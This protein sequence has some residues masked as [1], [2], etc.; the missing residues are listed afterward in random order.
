MINESIIASGQGF[1]THLPKN[2]GIL[3]HV[4]SSAVAHRDSMGNQA[5][6]HAAAF[7]IMRDGTGI[8]HSEYNACDDAPLHRYQV[9]ITPA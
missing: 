6:I 8:R 7:Q 2:M 9:W 1:G 5:Q 4:P 3:T